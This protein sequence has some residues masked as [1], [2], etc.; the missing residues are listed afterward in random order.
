M[1]YLDEIMQC[2]NVSLIIIDYI[3]YCE[4]CVKVKQLIKQKFT[5]VFM[6]INFGS[7]RVMYNHT[8]KFEIILSKTAPIIDIDLFTYVIS[9]NLS[10]VS[11]VN[12][13]KK[14][15]NKNRNNLHRYNLDAF[16][17]CD[18]QTLNIYNW[19]DVL[20]KYNT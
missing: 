7:T 8:K 10:F 11:L 6:G 16:D 9:H 14:L 1:E 17:I 20:N 15:T 13:I 4:K 12:N 5:R 18:I 2:K 3:Y 19:V